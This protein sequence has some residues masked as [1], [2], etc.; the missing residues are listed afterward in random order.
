MFAEVQVASAPPPP[1][2]F[3]ITEK[4]YG[5]NC[6]LRGGM[7]FARPH[8]S[9]ATQPRFFM[10]KQLYAAHIAPLQDDFRLSRPACKVGQAKPPTMWSRTATPKH[11]TFSSPV[12]FHA[13]SFR[14]ARPSMI[15]WLCLLIWGLPAPS[16]SR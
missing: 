12:R 16:D 5:G 6:C 2:R 9:P 15:S 11:G 13:E 1:P 7:V 14:W 8:A 4:L 3:V 10:T